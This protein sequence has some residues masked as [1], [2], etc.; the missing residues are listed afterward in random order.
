M[1]PLT[2]GMGYHMNSPLI[3]KWQTDTKHPSFMG[4]HADT[5]HYTYPFMA[6]PAAEWRYSIGIDWAGI[7]LIRVSGDDNLETYFKREIFDVV[8]VRSMT[9]YPTD[10]VKSK[11]MAMTYAVPGT[12]A[13]EIKKLPN[14]YEALPHSRV[15]SVDKMG[16]VLAGGAG[17]FGRARDYLT[18]LRAVLQCA[19][20]ATEVKGQKRL[21][22]TKAFQELFIDS[23]PAHTPKIGLTN[24]MKAMAYHD[25]ALMEDESRIGHSIGLCL[26]KVDS[27]YGKRGG[28]GCWDGA[29][30]TKF[31]IDP[32]T[33]IA[34][35]GEHVRGR[36][37]Q[38]KC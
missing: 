16:P 4:P 19:P 14:N 21:I 8:G 23:I 9:F 12:G 34:V 24:T 11:S 6:Q 22:S 3:M 35:S 26:N 29:A 18:I 5:H 20:D 10:E 32:V 33:R 2:E 25:P 30:Q 13:K 1:F 17:L 28:S 36:L 37:N 15:S 31:W 27:K 38:G 7:L